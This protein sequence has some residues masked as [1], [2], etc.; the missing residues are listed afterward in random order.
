ADR[1]PDGPCIRLGFHP[2]CWGKKIPSPQTSLLARWEI[3]PDPPGT[4]FNVEEN[5]ILWRTIQG[6]VRRD[7]SAPKSQNGP[8][9]KCGLSARLR[10]LEFSRSAKGTPHDP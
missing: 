10:V 3:P 2:F 4:K 7:R 9:R 8:G 5:Q 6:L 1:R